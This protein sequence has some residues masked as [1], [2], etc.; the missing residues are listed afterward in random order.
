M[1]RWSLFSWIALLPF[2]GC[3]T[4]KVDRFAQFAATGTDYTTAMGALLESAGETLVDADSYQLI[5]DRASG[6]VSAAE[7]QQHDESLRE[8]LRDI[9]LIQRQT[10]VL[11]QYFQA[12]ASSVSSAKNAPAQLTDHL[13]DLASSVQGLVQAV[14]STGLFKRDV[15]LVQDSS[16]LVE[17]V[18]DDAGKLVVKGVEDHRLK[19]ELKAHKEIIVRALRQQQAALVSISGILEK[20]QT[21][22]DGYT[23]QQNVVQPFLSSAPLPLDWMQ[24]RQAEL[25]SYGVPEAIQSAWSAAASLGLAWAQ[26]LSATFGDSEAQTL[27]ASVETLKASLAVASRNGKAAARPQAPP[28]VQPGL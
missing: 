28:P 20:A 14:G 15:S 12:L 26:L 5:G 6:P 2:A 1:K 25:T 18:A 11:G 21:V 8:P 9:R 19:K 23:Y 27:S 10:D 24:T 3:A 7:F 13:N 22:V 16:Q 4:A 17:T